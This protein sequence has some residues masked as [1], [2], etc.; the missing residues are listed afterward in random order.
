MAHQ[1]Q[2][3][4]AHTNV[5]TVSFD[6]LYWSRAWLQETGSPFPFLHDPER[7]AYRA[8]G[9]KS[10]L[11]RAWS[12]ANLWYYLKATWQGRPTFGRRGNPHQLGGD[13]IIDQHGLI[14][15]AHPSRE[16]T[17]RPTLAQILASLQTI[18]EI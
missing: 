17:D 18:N 9:L 4:A 3:Q 1:V 15:L 10:S 7:V 8:Y 5:V 13:F 12:P 11:W 16:P 14:Q 6:S 2:L